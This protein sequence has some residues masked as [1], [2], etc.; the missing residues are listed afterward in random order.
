MS[1]GHAV[2]AGGLF[3]LVLVGTI[4]RQEAIGVGTE[5]RGTGRFLGSQGQEECLRIE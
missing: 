4:A 5:D 2:R 3:F 1:E